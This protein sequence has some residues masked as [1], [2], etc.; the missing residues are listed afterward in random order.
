MSN[1]NSGGGCMG[2]VGF[3]VL[4]LIGLVCLKFLGC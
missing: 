4:C 2:C 1:D 3:V